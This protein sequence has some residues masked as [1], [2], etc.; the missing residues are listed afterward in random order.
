MLTSTA[1][2]VII[3]G[4]NLSC[5][6]SSMVEHQPSK[7]DTWVRFPSPAPKRQTTELPPLLRGFCPQALNK[8]DSTKIVF[9]PSF[10]NKS[11]M[12][13]V[14]FGRGAAACRAKKPRL[15]GFVLRQAVSDKYAPVAQVD[16]ATAHNC[17]AICLFKFVTFG[18]I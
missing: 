13:R 9:F 8:P 14:L 6:R 16:R 12:K 15:R 3:S 11:P 4:L 7:L 17:F 18:D 2:S 1:I 5:G 10:P